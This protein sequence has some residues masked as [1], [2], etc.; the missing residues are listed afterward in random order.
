MVEVFEE[1]EKLEL[2]RK[3]KIVEKRLSIDDPDVLN[4]LRKLST[5][6]KSLDITQVDFNPKKL[7]KVSTSEL[8]YQ[9]NRQI[10][11]M[12]KMEE[13]EETQKQEELWK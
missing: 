4:I 13:V 9:M 6:C 5:I 7:V 8:S 2:E 3:E 1:K 10:E 12:G 11:V